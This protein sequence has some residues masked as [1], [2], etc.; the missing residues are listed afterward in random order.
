MRGLRIAALL[1]LVYGL[2]MAV[3]EGMY[4]AWSSSFQALP[5]LILRV[6]GAVVMAY[7]L[8]TATRWAWWFGVTF[9]GLLATL[10]TAGLYYL[11]RSGASLS[12]RPVPAP[13]L[14]FLVVS[15]VTLAGVF[16]VLLLPSSRDAIR[17][18]GGGGG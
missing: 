7:G 18:R 16:A 17:R 10:G 8:W 6:G 12:G 11:G 15:T 9:S 4:M 13:D 2:A 5:R 3:N 1:I 14:F